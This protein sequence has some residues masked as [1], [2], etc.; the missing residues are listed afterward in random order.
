MVA[1]RNADA[2]KPAVMIPYKRRQFFYKVEL[3]FLS[4]VMNS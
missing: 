3:I 4:I 1:Q 2:G